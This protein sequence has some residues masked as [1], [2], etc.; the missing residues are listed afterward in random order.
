MHTSREELIRISKNIDTVTA[1]ELFCV[2]RECST[3]P[4]QILHLN[5]NH[6]EMYLQITPEIKVY[7]NEELKNVTR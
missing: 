3:C 6:E 5:C 7:K 2:G 4:Y 1:Y